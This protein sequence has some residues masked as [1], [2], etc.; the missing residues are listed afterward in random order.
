MLFRSTINNVFVG[1]ESG[2]WEEMRSDNYHDVD[3]CVKVDVDVGLPK[4]SGAELRQSNIRLY[5]SQNGYGEVELIAGKDYNWDILPEYVGLTDS[6]SICTRFAEFYNCGVPVYCVEVL[7]G[8]F[9][10]VFHH[11]IAGLCECVYILEGAVCQ[12]KPCQVA[13]YIT[14]FSLVTKQDWF[15]LTGACRGFPIVDKG[16]STSYYC[17]NYASLTKGSFLDEMT[18][19]V[20]DELLGGKVR[21]SVNKPRCVHSLGGVV[22]TDGSLRPITDCSSPDDININLYMDNTCSKFRYHSIDDVVDLLE[23]NEF[24]AVSDISSAYRSINVLPGHRQFQGFKWDIGSGDV[25]FNDLCLCFGLKCAPWIFTQVSDFCVKCTKL[26]GVD[27]CINYLD[28][29]IVI[30]KD[31]DSCESA[32]QNLHIVLTRLGFKIATKKVSPPAQVLTYLGIV[33]NT[34]EM[35][36]SLGEDKLERVISCV[37]ALKNK[38]WCARK[39][40]EQTAGLLAHCATVVRG[41]R[42][43]TRRIYDLL[44]DAGPQCKRIVLSELAMLDL[45]WWATFISSFNGKARMFDKSCEVV[46]LTTDASSSGFGGHSVYDYYWGFWGDHDPVCP[47]QAKAPLEPIYRDN[48]NVGELWPVLVALQRSCVSWKNCVVEVVTDNTQVY[49]E[50]RTGGGSNPTTMGW[51]REVFWT[52]AMFNIYIKPSWIKSEDNLLA[53]C[54]SRLRNVDSI[55]VCA[56]QIIDFDLCCRPRLT[57]G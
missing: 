23:P 52:T 28:D 43:Y 35:T 30:A 51:L 18:T 16:C 10:P 49:H 4:L 11:C 54:L 39:L 50:L 8:S 25:W 45:K 46:T 31:K 1:S 21:Q 29:F 27:R 55:T 14:R 26:E 9:I 40:L 12:L 48:I 15:V 53:D 36:L 2:L 41:G 38:K 56:D 13:G 37:T 22:K 6:V 17:E 34:M 42:T 32:Q 20:K 47:H 7:P 24:C 3:E 44:R 33:I 5:K 19:K 57:E